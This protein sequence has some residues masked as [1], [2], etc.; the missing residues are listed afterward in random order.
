V[1]TGPYNTVTKTLNNGD[2]VE[3]KSLEE[4]KKDSE[5]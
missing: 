2:K 4:D 1:I 3:E 5:E